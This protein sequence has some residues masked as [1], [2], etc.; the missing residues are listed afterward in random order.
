MADS[1]IQEIVDVLANPYLFGLP[2]EA[3]VPVSV[4]RRGELFSQALITL[5][6]SD[7]PATHKGKNGN[8][9][10]AARAFAALPP[11]GKPVFGSVVWSGKGYDVYIYD[12]LGFRLVMAKKD[13]RLDSPDKATARRNF[14]AALREMG[15]FRKSDIFSVRVYVSNDELSPR[16]DQIL[17]DGDI[18]ADAYA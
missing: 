10:I 16:K 7:Y 15:Q 5:R 2:V 3:S 13:V 17:S 1:A 9:Y 14:L 6:K 12:E 8:V 11:A 4:R 18:E